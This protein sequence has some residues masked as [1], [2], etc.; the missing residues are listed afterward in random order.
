MCFYQHY[1]QMGGIFGTMSQA[2]RDELLRL[3]GPHHAACRPFRPSGL[4][5]LS[6]RITMERTQPSP[7][8][9][10]GDTDCGKP[11]CLQAIIAAE[12]DDDF[13]RRLRQHADAAASEDGPYREG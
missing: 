2:K 9:I 3:H 1:I 10:C 8:R 13:R 5:A 6:A 11:S 7:C 12:E 4:T